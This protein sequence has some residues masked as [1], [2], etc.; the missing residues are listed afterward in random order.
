MRPVRVSAKADYAVRAMIELAA[1][2]SSAERPATAES[3]ARAQAIPANFLER[4]LSELRTNGLIQSRRGSDGGYWL[5][6]EPEAI[7]V[8]DVIRTV[9][10]P[11]AAVRGD[12]PDK[13]EYRGSAEPLRDV[14]IALRASVRD[15]L[16][17]V[18]LADLSAGAP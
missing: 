12:D 14:W 1:G 2:G 18:S 11:L 9:D 17:S 15:V 7:T 6:R 4:I 16:E 10:G 8:A 5:A 3:I 13:V